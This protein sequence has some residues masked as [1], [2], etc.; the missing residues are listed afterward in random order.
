MYIC[1]LQ[2]PARLYAF[3][4]VTHS[5]KER[6]RGEVRLNDAFQSEGVF[7]SRLGERVCVYVCL[8]M[9]ACVCVFVCACVCV[10]V[11]VCVC[12]CVCVCMP[13]PV[14]MCVCMC[15]HVCGCVCACV[16]LCMR[17]CVRAC[18]CVCVCTCNYVRVCA[19]VHVCMRVC[20]R[21][22]MC[23]CVCTCNYVHVCMRA[24]VHACMCGVTVT[25]LVHSSLSLSLLPPPPLSPVMRASGS[26]RVLLNTHLWAQMKCDRANQKNIRITAQSTDGKI[27][28]FLIMVRHIPVNYEE[29]RRGEGRE[30]NL[31]PRRDR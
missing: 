17:V 13:V 2:V 5:W 28:V 8:C 25:L 20:V 18:M 21:A 15:V 26:Y 14:C 16:H 4:V 31:V 10:F 30:G 6:G 24:Y 22:C 23:V 7:Q 3:D 9:C 1:L 27:S 29:G 19:C 11:C 12:L